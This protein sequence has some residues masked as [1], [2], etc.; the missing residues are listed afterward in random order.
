ML[1][2]AWNSSAPA[3]RRAF[4]RSI[5]F[6][7]T[8][9]KGTKAK[10]ARKQIDLGWEKLTA[11]L[12]AAQLSL[13][14]LRS[15][16]IEHA[17][18]GAGQTGARKFKA[19]LP[20]LRWQNPDSQIHTAWLEDTVG[21]PRV[22]LEFDSGERTEFDVEGK[23]S[24]EILGEVLRVAG[25]SEESV[26]SSVEWAAAFLHKRPSTAKAHEMRRLH[27]EPDEPAGI[28]GDVE[29]DDDHAL[30]GAASALEHSR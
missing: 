8:T 23:R 20:P 9:L 13:P 6:H 12:D 15:L 4:T 21:P 2:S 17:S 11:P 28:E 1:P 27:D 29:D 10:K 5:S 26:A 16:K 3:L 14:K 19:L 25:A 30:P 24:E 22:L 18:Q 7:P